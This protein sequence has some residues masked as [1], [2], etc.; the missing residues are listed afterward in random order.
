MP[1]SSW[2]A[3]VTSEDF[4]NVWFST[5]GVVRRIPQLANLS[6]N[7]IQ[8]I[9][10]LKGAIFANIDDEAKWTAGVIEHVQASFPNWIPAQQYESAGLSFALKYLVENRSLHIW[11]KCER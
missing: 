4:L 5:H 7:C 8:Q 11:Q 3:I 9:C 1:P 10:S 2:S 6:S